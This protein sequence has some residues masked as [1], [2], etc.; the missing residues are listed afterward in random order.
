MDLPKNSPTPGSRKP[1]QVFQTAGTRTPTSTSE[2]ISAQRSSKTQKPVCSAAELD[3]QKKIQQILR[4]YE[5]ISLCSEENRPIDVISYI[6]PYGC[7]A[8]IYFGAREGG[9]RINAIG[10]LCWNVPMG[11]E[12]AFTSSRE[13][14]MP[15]LGYGIQQYSGQLLAALA[16]ARVPIDYRFPAGWAELNENSENVNA[17]PSANEPASLENTE[18]PSESSE[19][20]RSGMPRGKKRFGIQNLVEFEQKN[21]RWSRD[22]SQTLIALSYYLPPDAEWESGDG[23]TWTLERLVKNELDRPVET[24]SSAA[25]NQLLGLLCA[26]RCRQMRTGDAPLE[27]QYARAEKFLESWRTYVLDLQ[28]EIGIW[29][30]EF[31]LK[32]GVTPN[33][34]TEMLLSSGHILRWLV[35]VTPRQELND[36]RIFKAV[37][38]I[39]ELL[40]FQL[41]YWNPTNASSTEIEGI[42]AALHALA[43]YEKRRF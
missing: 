39:H 24:G 15:R 35:T 12:S 4:T 16:I 41:M 9:R 30:P 31:F 21:C 29:H 11:D 27:G 19:E 8:E 42:M 43:I 36:P 26:I 18:E 5:H 14:L 40:E 6:V 1:K 32:K 22:L 37:S 13:R 38:T 23:E 17:L 33:R 10:A 34:P 28:N 3:L 2:A 7:D 25:T 20:L